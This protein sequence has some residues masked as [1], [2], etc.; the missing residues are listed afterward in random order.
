MVISESCATMLVAGCALLQLACSEATG[1]ERGEQILWSVPSG[2]STNGTPFTPAANASRSMAYFATTDFRLK[3]VRGSN[4]VVIWNV[5]FGIPSAVFPTLNAVVAGDVVA[6]SKLNILA[7]DTATGAARW[8]YAPSDGEQTG[9]SPLASNDSTIFAAGRF[10]HLHAVNAKTGAPRW[11]AD[12][13]EGK[14]NV[15]TFNP[16]LAGDAVF[17]CS[18]DFAANP[19][20]GALWAVDALTGSVRWSHHFSGELPGQGSACFGSA[21]VWNDLV[22]EPQED[23]RVYAFDRLT[24]QVR[25]IAPRAHNAAASLNDIRYPAV[26][27][28]I[29][30]VTSLANAGMIVAY[31]AATGLERWRQLTNGG[32]LYPPA[33]DSTV[34]YVD[35]GWIFASY[36]MAT[37]KVRWQTPQSVFDPETPY[38]GT[39]VIAVDRIFVSAR[40]GSYALRR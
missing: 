37:G 10:G 33:V 16:T 25:W 9:N 13:S 39:P 5:S 11:I 2:P 14:A 32:S 4:G 1:P 38:K 18:K 28:N 7:Y 21:V 23:G 35:H 36:D 17:V 8:T 26:G 6:V 30:V 3:K 27:G 31:D 12:L 24:G 40:N 34:A 29:V 19:S 22:I 20:T 15:G